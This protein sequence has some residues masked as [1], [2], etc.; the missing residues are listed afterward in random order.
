MIEDYV[1]RWCR[2]LCDKHDSNI[3]DLLAEN[4]VLYSPVVFKPKHGRDVVNLFLTAAREVF[5]R[6][7]G[8][9]FKYVH[10]MMQDNKALLEFETTVDGKYVNG[11]DI[12]T[13]DGAGQIAEFKLMLRPLQGL[14]AIN[15]AMTR[16]IEAKIGKKL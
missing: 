4:A 16:T 8:A 9:D 12:I 6:A 14:Q 2:F 13:Y 1:D 11:I 15:E 3:A 7:G 10:K 5:V